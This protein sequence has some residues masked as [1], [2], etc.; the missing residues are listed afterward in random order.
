MYPQPQR[1]YVDGRENNSE[2][3]AGLISTP[4][5]K[6]TVASQN[7]A[8]GTID[9]WVRGTL[10][11]AAVRIHNGTLMPLQ[12]LLNYLAEKDAYPEMPPVSPAKLPAGPL[13]RYSFTVDATD[14][15]G[16]ADATAYGVVWFENGQAVLDNIGTERSDRNGLSPPA[17]P[18]GAYLD[19]PNGILSS[20]GRSATIEM[21]TTWNGPLS[22]VWQRILDFGTSAGGENYPTNGAQQS[23]MF[24]TPR[25]G[26][27]TLRLGIRS[28][29]N[30]PFIPYE[31]R[32][33]NEMPFLPKGTEQHIAIVWDGEKEVIS[34]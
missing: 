12:V 28:G 31:E 22:A 34:L 30:I 15:T 9:W 17:P 25:S 26:D 10:S 32:N 19:F 1:V 2:G 29:A 18:P 24:L 27:S 3:T 33:I 16:G 11:I 5:A 13:H 14:S 23:Y 21:W 4:P 20:L 8:D 6:I 7:A